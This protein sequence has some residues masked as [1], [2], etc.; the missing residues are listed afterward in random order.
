MNTTDPNLAIDPALLASLAKNTDVA[1]PRIWPREERK[2]LFTLKTYEDERGLLLEER[3]PI[4][5]ECSKQQPHYKLRIVI[6]DQ[7]TNRRFVHWE[8]VEATDPADAYSQYSTE[9]IQARVQEI[10]EEM[11]TQ[12]RAQ[13]LAIQEASRK[14]TG[15]VITGGGFRR[16]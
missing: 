2:A 12:A 3:T 14:A 16:K 8:P 15:K 1:G 6:Q 10:I 9:R 13:Q 5:G 7:E 4:K 11:D